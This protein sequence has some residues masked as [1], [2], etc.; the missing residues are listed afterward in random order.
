MMVVGWAKMGSG[1][2]SGWG[3]ATSRVRVMEKKRQRLVRHEDW[4]ASEKT[5]ESKMERGR[6]SRDGRW[7][8]EDRLD[9]ERAPTR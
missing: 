9:G 8:A 2:P 4:S 6:G 3:Q 5:C 7:T 1:G